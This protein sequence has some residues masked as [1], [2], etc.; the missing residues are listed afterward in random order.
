MGKT[1]E[2][3]SGGGTGRVAFMGGINLCALGL[4][5]YLPGVA[6]EP[7]NTHLLS[8]RW[9]S[10]KRGGFGGRFGPSNNY[11]KSP[12]TPAIIYGTQKRVQE[13]AR[14]LQTPDKGCRKISGIGNLPSP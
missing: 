10:Y 9:A 3:Q 5:F 13:Q 6:L 14:L 1:Q 11:D 7:D 8:L 4:L 12:L 2:S